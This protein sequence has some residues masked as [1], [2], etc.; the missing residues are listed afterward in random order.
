MSSS[1]S[2]IVFN[3]QR[4]S[5]DDG[6]GIRTCVF[7]KGCPLHCLWCHNVESQCYKRELSFD[8]KSCIGCRSCEL[9]CSPKCHVFDESG[10][11][12]FERAKCTMCG[13]CVKNCPTNALEYVGN[14]YTVEE[15][16]EIV[17]KDKAYYNKNGGVTLSGGEPMAQYDFTYSL[18]KALKNNNINTAIE[19]SGFADTDRLTSLLEFCDLFLFDCKAS[20]EDHQMLTGAED[21]LIIKNL[22]A[23]CKKGANVVLRC[24]M[25]KG[26]N[27][28]ESY[29]EKI[30]CI[31]KMNPEIRRIELLPYHK[32]G[33]KKTE[34]LGYVSQKAFETPSRAELNCIKET[35]TANTDIQVIVR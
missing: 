10:Y 22:N 14:V 23:L 18:L 30:I 28:S 26:G 32:S 9:V 4:F 13:E 31:G 21:K 33:L 29:I 11:H 27:L 6:D 1:L 12:L 24:P 25:V 15:L 19:T 34:R 20:E 7:L 17:I 2:G 35:I 16:L 8:S 3:I 5:L